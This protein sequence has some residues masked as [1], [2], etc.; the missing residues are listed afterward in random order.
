MHSGYII[1][2]QVLNCINALDTHLT[3][4]K[5]QFDFFLHSYFECPSKLI[6]NRLRET[7]A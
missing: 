7:S 3:A 1:L 4:P 5:K 6:Q 2:K